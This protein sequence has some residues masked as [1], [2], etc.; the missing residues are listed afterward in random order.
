MSIFG[1]M[2]LAV[3]VVSVICRISDILSF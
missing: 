3:N 1:L 2:S